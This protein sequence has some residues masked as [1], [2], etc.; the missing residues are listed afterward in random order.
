MA[1]LVK[2]AGKLNI[3]YL[4]SEFKNHNSNLYKIFTNEFSFKKE[5]TT[6]QKFLNLSKIKSISKRKNKKERDSMVSGCNLKKAESIK[7]KNIHKQNLKANK[8]QYLISNNNKKV[9]YLINK[10]GKKRTSKK[11]NSQI[12]SS[13]SLKNLKKGKNKSSS[14][15][16]KLSFRNQH[17]SMRK[18]NKKLNFL[19]ASSKVYS[20]KHKRPNNQFK[21]FLK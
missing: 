16:K 7:I 8:I 15:K 14:F 2:K 1:E 10:H 11:E 5:A 18:S 12:N 21:S 3:K 20:T 19:T 17:H 9:Y 6:T 4:Q 13:R